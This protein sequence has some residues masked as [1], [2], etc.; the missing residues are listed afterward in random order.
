MLELLGEHAGNIKGL[1]NLSR[2]EQ[3][4]VAEDLIKR[5]EKMHHTSG[6]IL[7]LTKAELQTYKL[8]LELDEGESES[9]RSPRKKQEIISPDPEESAGTED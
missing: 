1:L 8:R 9:G 6:E 4:E 3:I 2:T 7:N 5:M